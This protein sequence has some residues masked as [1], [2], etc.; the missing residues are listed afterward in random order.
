[1]LAAALA[2]TAAWRHSTAR[3][4]AESTPKLAAP[5]IDTVSALGRLEPRTRVI[6]LT[7]PGDAYMA[8]VQELKVREGDRVAEG[9]I[10]AILDGHRQKAVAVREAELKLRVERARLAQIK[11]GAKTGDLRAQ[12]AAVARA[13]VTLRNSQADHDR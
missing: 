7:V 12:E 6:E 13:E 9:Q 3:T 8:R 5:P 1:V 2:L 11:A 4:P 10:V